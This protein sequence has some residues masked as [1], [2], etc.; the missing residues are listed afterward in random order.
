MPLEYRYFSLD[1]RQQWE[2]NRAE[3]WLFWKIDAHGP[4]AAVFDMESKINLLGTYD[5]RQ[6]VRGK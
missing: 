5:R 2:L 6:R 1:K 4:D 3:G